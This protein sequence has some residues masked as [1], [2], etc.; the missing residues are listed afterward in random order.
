MASIIIR[1]LDEGT[2]EKLRIRAAH[3]G[4]SME[5][6]ARYILRAALI[7]E[8]KTNSNLANR[9]R[10]KFQPLGGLDLRLPGREPMRQ[11]PELD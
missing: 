5:D 11:P 7:D 3:N 1:K 8:P 9:I 2:K 6:E 4:R 10:K